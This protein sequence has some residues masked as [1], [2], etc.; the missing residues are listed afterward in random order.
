M[1]WIDSEST[2]SQHCYEI[3]LWNSW[4]GTPEFWS[5]RGRQ[6]VGRLWTQGLYELG[7]IVLCSS[8]RIEFIATIETAHAIQLNLT[9]AIHYWTC[10]FLNDGIL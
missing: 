1:K 9:A 6:L 3:V 4:G 10:V 5:L 8:R 7:F 2:M